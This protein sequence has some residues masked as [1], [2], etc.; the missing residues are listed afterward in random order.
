MHGANL[1]ALSGAS[2]FTAAFLL[3]ELSR[4]IS[5]ANDDRVRGTERSLGGNLFASEESERSVFALDFHLA[6]AAFVRGKMGTN[7]RQLGSDTSGHIR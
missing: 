1:V 5:V 4:H 2:G 3:C 7:G 6:A